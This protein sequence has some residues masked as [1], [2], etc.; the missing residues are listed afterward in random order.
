MLTV[1]CI[2]KRS[3]LVR[4]F[5]LGDL[6]DVL[7]IERASFGRDAWNKGLFLEF[8]RRSPSLFLV[9]CV[10]RRI[11]AYSITTAGLR[12]AELASIAVNPRDRGRGAARALLDFS[13]AKLR[14]WHIQSWWL[15][16][17]VENPGAIRFYE[18]YG[19]V[20]MRRVKGY[21]GARRDG[22]RMRMG[23]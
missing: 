12:R 23:I 22:W 20:T 14:E 2:L 1:S 21:Y 13:I 9:A 3:V 15:M 16:V 8:F 10:G 11:V 6:D 17:D 7:A 19:F 5:E 4:R 18:K